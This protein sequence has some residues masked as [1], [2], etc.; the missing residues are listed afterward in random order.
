MNILKTSIKNNKDKLLVT[1]IESKQR[2][3]QKHTFRELNR[4]ESEKP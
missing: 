1:A 4:D 3:D 2:K